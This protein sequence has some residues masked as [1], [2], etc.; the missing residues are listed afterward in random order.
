MELKN[1]KLFQWFHNIYPIPST[2]FVIL[3]VGS[4]LVAI[5]FT[6]PMQDEKEQLIGIL[7]IEK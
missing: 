7:N 5:A 6:I 1:D 2:H 4:H 3:V